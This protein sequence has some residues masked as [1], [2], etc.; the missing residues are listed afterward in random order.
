V[1]EVWPL[2]QFLHQLLHVEGGG[3][4][5]VDETGLLVPARLITASILIVC[6]FKS[7]CVSNF[8]FFNPEGVKHASI[9][10]RNYRYSSQRR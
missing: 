6:C 10:V 4:L 8:Y 1:L 5:P 7:A 2:L 3:E 9:H